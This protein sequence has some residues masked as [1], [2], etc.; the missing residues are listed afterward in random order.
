MTKIYTKR[1]V[2]IVWGLVDVL[3]QL[4]EMLKGVFEFVHE[5]GPFKR[6]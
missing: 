3:H 4:V 2:V 6:L 5:V 1:V